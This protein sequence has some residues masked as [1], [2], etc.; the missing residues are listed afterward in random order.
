MRIKGLRVDVRSGKVEEVFEE[1]DDAVYQQ[2]LEEMR[3]LEEERKREELIRLKK[4]EILRRQAVEELIKEGKLK[5]EN[6]ARTNLK[7]QG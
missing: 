1:I 3:R 6:L 5:E 7:T 4:E 2:R